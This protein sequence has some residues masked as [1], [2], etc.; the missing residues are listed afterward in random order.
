[1]L[2][3]LRA[4][5]LQY[6]RGTKCLTRVLAQNV[7]Q[8]PTRIA[9]SVARRSITVSFSPASRGVSEMSASITVQRHPTDGF[10]LFAMDEDG[11]MVRKRFIGFSVSEAES[12]FRKEYDLY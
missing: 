8:R 9:R 12:I 6:E 7:K 11:Y 1:M 10:T 3:L 2:G 5:G 4:R